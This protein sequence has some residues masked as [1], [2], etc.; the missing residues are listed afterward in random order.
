MSIKLNVT[1]EQKKQLANL[2]VE[3]KVLFNLANERKFLMEQV[4]AKIL[5]DNH[6]DPKLYAMQF[7]SGKDN[8]TAT[9]KPGSISIPT[10]GT[11]ISNIKTN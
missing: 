8:W 4:G 6:L 11:D 1:G 9:L 5:Q 2:S 3:S 7:N 10:P